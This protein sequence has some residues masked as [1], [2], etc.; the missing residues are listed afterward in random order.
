MAKDSVKKVD[1]WHTTVADKPGAANEVLQKLAAAKQNLTAYLAFPMAGGKSQ[2]DL[3]PADPAGFEKAAKAAGIA[4]SPRKAAILVSGADRPG[5][6]AE[7]TK[8][9]AA[10][11]VNCTA[12]SAVAT[13]GG[14]YGFLLWVRPES[15][16][17]AAAAL[18]S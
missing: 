16:D 12:G 14:G 4:L 6:L 2:V 15:V 5:A 1:Y 10:K 9:L 17:A 7:H 3:V 13:P 11:G 18:S 8:K